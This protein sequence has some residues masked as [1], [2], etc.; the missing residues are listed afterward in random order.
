MLGEDAAAVQDQR[1]HVRVVQLLVRMV[2]AQR[3][4]RRR[5]HTVRLRDARRVH[6]ANPPA[7]EHHLGTDRVARQSGD[8]SRD[9]AVLLQQR[10]E[11]RRFAA[12]RNA[13]DGQLQNLVIAVLLLLRLIPHIN[14]YH[15]YI[16]LDIVRLLGRRALC[17]LLLQQC[18]ALA[19][20]LL[21]QVQQVAEWLQQLEHVDQAL[22]VLR[23]NADRLAEPQPVRLRTQ[24]FPLRAGAVH[25]RVGEDALRLRGIANRHSHLV[26]HR[27]DGELL[28]V[29]L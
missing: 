19:V 5:Q 4:E 24:V 13:Q 7:L 10:I 22:A 3:I 2:D 29:A 16:R 6:N 23:R 9:E 20:R 14:S 1:H 27:E 28:D 11:Q 15:R 26:H 12:V 18:V 25:V 8:A 21:V 17:L